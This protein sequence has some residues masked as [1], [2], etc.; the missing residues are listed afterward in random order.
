[1]TLALALHL[2]A[3]ALSALGAASGLYAA[4]LA[5]RYLRR[6]PDGP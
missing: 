6:P 4:A 1:V 2:V 3:L 5:H